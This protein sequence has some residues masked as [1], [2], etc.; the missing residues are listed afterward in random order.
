MFGF[1]MHTV[2][3]YKVALSVLVLVSPTVDFAYCCDLDLW[4][5]IFHIKLVMTEI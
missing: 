2:L 3:Q 5:R 4:K 1:T